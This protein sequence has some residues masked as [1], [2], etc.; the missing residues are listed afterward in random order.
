MSETPKIAQAKRLG[1]RANRFGK[2]AILSYNGSVL[3]L[4]L[5][6]INEF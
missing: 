1:A 6:A 4:A 5:T 3:E 2:N